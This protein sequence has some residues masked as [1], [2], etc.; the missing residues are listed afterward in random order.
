M[1]V[2][3]SR[4]QGGAFRRGKSRFTAAFL[5]KKF[6]VLVEVEIGADFSEENPGETKFSAANLGDK[7]TEF[8]EVDIRTEL[9]EETLDETVNLLAQVDV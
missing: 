2:I 4:I 7:F 3:L 5:C 8:A 1:M 9:T 6:T